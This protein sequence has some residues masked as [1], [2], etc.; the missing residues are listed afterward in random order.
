MSF[1]ISFLKTTVTLDHFI[2]LAIDSSYVGTAALES[3]GTIFSKFRSPKSLGQLL[4]KLQWAKTL[5]S[6]CTV[7]S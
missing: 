2:F 1:H 7:S 5:Q 4:Q 3:S 6:G